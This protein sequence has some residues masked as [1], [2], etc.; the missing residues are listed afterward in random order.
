MITRPPYAVDVRRLNEFSALELYALLKLR[1]DIF[2]VEQ[3]CAYPELDGQ[4]GAALHLRLMDGADILAAARVLPP[5][6]GKEPRIGRVLVSPAHRGKGLGEALMKEA[7]AVC[8][9]QYPGSDIAISAQ[10]YLLKFYSDLGFVAVSE[11]YVE[12]GIPHI[13]MVK[14]AR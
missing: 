9:E 10:S 1:V 12:D 2:V 7:L 13:D 4:D 3:E 8:A 14:A 6:E 5:I 11:E